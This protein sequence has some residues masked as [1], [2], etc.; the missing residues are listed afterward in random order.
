MVSTVV[1]NK[2]INTYREVNAKLAYIKQKFGRIIFRRSFFGGFFYDFGVKDFGQAVVPC[3]GK[4]IKK[5][6]RV[7]ERG[8][9]FY[10]MI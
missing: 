6:F 9:I 7:F 10:K 2:F 3:T 4:I 5:C 1:W 8:E